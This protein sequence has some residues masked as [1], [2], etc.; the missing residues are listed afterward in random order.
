MS[1]QIWYTEGEWLHNTTMRPNPRATSTMSKSLS[2]ASWMYAPM[3][4]VQSMRKQ[5]S[6]VLWTARSDASVRA[7]EFLAGQGKLGKF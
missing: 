1:E 4:P 3:L 7:V 2:L 5:R 6:M